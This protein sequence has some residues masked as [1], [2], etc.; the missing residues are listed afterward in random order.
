MRVTET[1]DG[2]KVHAVAGTYVVLLGFDLPEA[3]CRGLLGFSI[4]RVDHTQNEA[5]FLEGM[6]AFAETDPGFPPGSQ[7]STKDH[8]I[9][10]FQWA[11][12]TAKPGSI[13]ALR[14]RRPTSA[15][16]AIGRPTRCRTG[17]RSFGSRVA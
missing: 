1:N 12:Y 16:S 3:D 14:D 7:Y 15:A 2:L 13:V 6:K 10:S 8:P 4:H 17:R 9:Q 5:N 11:D